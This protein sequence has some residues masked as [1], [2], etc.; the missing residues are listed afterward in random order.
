MN[1]METMLT[2]R[3]QTSIPAPVRK[4]MRLTPGVKLRW[5]E[6]SEHECRVIVQC[7]ER[8]PGARAMLGYAK[9]FRKSRPTREWMI[10]LRGG[11]QA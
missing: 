9:S 2:E 1:R 6:L 4:H 5:Q 8:G 3:G 11:E 7:R 10:E